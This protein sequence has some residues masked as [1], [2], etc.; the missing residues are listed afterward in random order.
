MARKNKI[1]SM[2]PAQPGWTVA[3]NAGNGELLDPGPV[4]VWALVE[5]ENGNQFIE[6]ITPGIAIDWTMFD[7]VEYHPP[8]DTPDA[9]QAPTMRRN[10]ATT[11]PLYVM[12]SWLQGEPPTKQ[13]GRNYALIEASEMV[14]TPQGAY[15][16]LTIKVVKGPAE[17]MRFI[18]RLHLQSPDCT[19]QEQSYKRLSAYCHATGQLQIMDS[20]QFHGIPFWVQLS[21][22]GG[23]LTARLLEEKADRSFTPS[24]DNFCIQVAE[25]A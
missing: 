13:T 2:V 15:L 12:P 3:L 10:P 21:K 1:I 5:D 7:G 16:E 18:D 25:A 23:A 14:G 20:K 24:T 4:A 11:E 6:G 8:L 22:R 9:G 19:L 17:G